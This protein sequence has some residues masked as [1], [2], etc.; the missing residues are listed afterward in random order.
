MIQC[1]PAASANLTRLGE[2]YCQW[3]ENCS[4]KGQISTE[5]RH[6]RFW[7]LLAH[8]SS[9]VYTALISP[10]DSSKCHLRKLAM[11]FHC[12]NILVDAIN[13]LCRVKY[14]VGLT[15]ALNPLV[16][17]LN[18]FQFHKPVAFCRDIER[19][20]ASTVSRWSWRRAHDLLTGTLHPDPWP[21]G[22]FYEAGLVTVFV[23]R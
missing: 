8:V 11:S 20:L 5:L 16:I 9:A 7:C 13:M 22:C 19:L 21:P 23:Q 4:P 12:F 17:Y 6:W 3:S 15:G 1:T 18:W 2:P 10:G 14:S